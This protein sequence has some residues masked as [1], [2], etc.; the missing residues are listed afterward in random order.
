MLYPPVCP[1]C[2]AIS[3]PGICAKCREKIIYVQEPRCMRCGKPLQDESEEY[4]RDCGKE[5]SWFVQGRSLWLHR[6]PVPSAIYRF[7]Y[8]NRRHF[9]KIFAGELKENYGCQIRKWK[10]HE[11]IPIPLHTSRRRKRGFNQSEIIAGELARLTGIPCR[12]DVLFRIR[13]TVP[14][15]ELDRRGR[16]RELSGAFA[17]AKNWNA[18]E[19]VL[20]IDDIYTTGATL[21]TAAR[22]LRA[23]GVQNVYFLTVSIGQG[24]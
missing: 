22:M 23:A 18:P 14:L 15:K 12:S 13:K 2:G 1:F 21:Q 9:G 19:N 16:A 11:I 5:K 10:I 4:C 6:D 8:Q 17:V 20:L 24:I 7:K 3:P